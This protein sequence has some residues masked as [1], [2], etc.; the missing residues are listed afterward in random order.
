MFRS[1]SSTLPAHKLLPMSLTP[2]IEM[3]CRKSVK[4]GLLD[5]SQCRIVKE[6]IS[7]DADLGEFVQTVLEFGVCSNPAAAKQLKDEIQTSWNGMAPE[8]RLMVANEMLARSDRGGAGGDTLGLDWFCFFAITEGCLTKET[9][10]SIAAEVEDLTD[11]LMFA[12][13]VIDRWTS[14]DFTKLQHCVDKASIM[15]RTSKAVPPFRVFGRLA[16]TSNAQATLGPPP[17]SPLKRQ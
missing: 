13:A 2:Q 11:V 12:Q 3:F 10:L 17:K 16:G 4:R 8:E 14:N 7:Q 9:C 5:E 6:M 15:V 1:C